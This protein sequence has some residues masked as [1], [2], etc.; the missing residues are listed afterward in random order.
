MS[1]FNLKRYSLFCVF[2]TGFAKD[3]TPIRLWFLSY[4]FTLDKYVTLSNEAEV[5][6]AVTIFLIL[7]VLSVKSLVL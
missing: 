6:E 1:S 5:C 3:A 4:S 2:L 7:D